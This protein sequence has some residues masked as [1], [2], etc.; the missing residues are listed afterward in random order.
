MIRYQAERTKSLIGR[1]LC[2]GAFAILSLSMSCQGDSTTTQ[3][4]GQG[5]ASDSDWIANTPDNVTSDAGQ[6][7]CLASGCDD[8]AFCYE[9]QGICIK[10]C[11][12]PIQMEEALAQHPAERAKLS[13]QLVW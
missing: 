3:N 10:H 12:D 1:L 9:P 8:G 11:G 13:K 2:F 5:R 6:A 7:A 4:D